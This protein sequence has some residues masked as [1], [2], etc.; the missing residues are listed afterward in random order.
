MAIF[1]KIQTDE[2]YLYMNGKLIYKRWLKQGYSKVFDIM[3]YDRYTLA[4]FSDLEYENPNVDL[5][6]LK[7]KLTLKNTRDGGRE[8]GIV[9]GYRPN[10]V[11]EYLATGQI[12]DTFIGDIQFD[13]AKFI[14][15]GESREVTVRFLINQP[16]EKYLDK[17]R[18]WWLHEGPKV[19]GEAEIL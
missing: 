6:T 7:A 9:S 10:H 12:K 15:P 2:L 13:G 8:T 18:K 3:A 5:I 1:K 17:G 19:M 4:S 16:I 11:F 14:E